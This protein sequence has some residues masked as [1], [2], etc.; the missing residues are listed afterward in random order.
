MP[1]LAVPPMR[2]PRHSSR[3]P[4][5]T[6]PIDERIPQHPRVLLVD[7]HDGFRTQVRRFLEDEDVQVVAEAR[8]GHE[9][10]A[11]VILQAPDVAVVDLGLQPVNG[12]VLRSSMWVY[13]VCP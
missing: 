3:P 5:L 2:R 7:G 12:L 11:A 6:V 13:V 9:A 10:V 1:P 8:D 4:A